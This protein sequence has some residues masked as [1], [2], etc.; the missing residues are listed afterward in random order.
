MKE[1]KA[2][3]I[4]KIKKAKTKELGK[5]IFY[6]KEID[7]TQDE[8][9]RLIKQGN[10]KNGSLIIADRQT[11]GKG[12][13]QNKWYTG[14][15]KNIAM[16]MLLFPNCKVADL[17]GITLEIAKWIQ[18]TIQE[19]YNYKLSIKPPNDLYLNGKKICGILTQTM[20]IG[21]KVEALIIGIGFNV[22]ENNFNEETKDIATSLSREYKKEFE[23]EDVVIKFI[24]IFE[25]K[26]T[27]FQ[28]DSK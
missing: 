12:T 28:R 21:E 23:K 2:M 20:S 5:T 1:E 18:E 8:A 17:E 24:E 3:N 25:S 6:H 9:F 22:N 26:F 11:K 27:E 7:S 16:T 14:A 4:E 19:L 13:K 10:C 15:G